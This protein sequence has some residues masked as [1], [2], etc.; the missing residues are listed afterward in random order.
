MPPTMPILTPPRVTTLLGHRVEANEVHPPYHCLSIGQ[1]ADRASLPHVARGEDDR[2]VDIFRI[3]VFVN[4][5][6]LGNP[7]LVLSVFPVVGHAAVGIVDRIDVDR[8]DFASLAIHVLFAIKAYGVDLKGA[9]G[10]VKGEITA[11][12]FEIES[13][14]RCEGLGANRSI[15][16]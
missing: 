14:S 9:D 2:T 13:R 3:R 8:I 12:I 15:V 5:R 10:R 6:E 11:S 7:E 4:G 1:V 16:D